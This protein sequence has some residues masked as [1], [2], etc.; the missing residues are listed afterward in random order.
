M[1]AATRSGVTVNLLGR[2]A[3][4]SEIGADTVARI[5]NV[6]GGT[7]KDSLTGDD[8]QN[9]LFGQSGDDQLFG[10]LGNDTLG[11]GTGSDR[12]SGGAGLDFFVFDAKPNIKTNLDKISD[13]VAAD[14]T[15]LPT[16]PHDL[17]GS[18]VARRWDQ[19]NCLL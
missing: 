9:S 19:E 7:G 16:E 10:G 12:L 13:Y 1:F 2:S 5:E 8:G 14:D 18:G 17:Q 15:I 11:G 3:R 6:I 4:G